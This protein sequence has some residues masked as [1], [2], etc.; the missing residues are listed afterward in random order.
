M[1]RKSWLAGLVCV[2]FAVFSPSQG[3]WAQ[4]EENKPPPAIRIDANESDV[5]TALFLI[6]SRRFAEAH[7]VLDQVIARYEA[8]NNKEGTTYYSARSLMETVSYLADAT[9][10]NKDAVVAGEN[11]GFAIYAKGYALIEQRNFQEA[12]K[13]LE[14]AI[15][16]SPRNSQFLAERGHLYQHERRWAAAIDQFKLAEAA[17]REFSPESRRKAEL[18]RALRGQGFSYV[19]LGQFDDA[20]RVYKECLQLDP[21]DGQA[22]RELKL[23]ASQRPR[24][25]I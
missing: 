2:A 16:L 20:E 22:I 6:Q 8:A 3:A 9:K 25:G 23:I 24:R 12:A 5:Q 17:A 10:A 7:Q 18:G 13:M 21:D 11:W 15:A 19:E 4:S 14:R 1:N